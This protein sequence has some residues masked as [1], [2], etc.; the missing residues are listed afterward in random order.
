MPADDD[1]MAADGL[2]DELTSIVSAAAAAIIA[3]C[4]G[5]LDTRTKADLTPVTAA[6]HAAE[7]VIL[8]GLARLLPD[9]CVVSE[10]AVGRALPDRI[11]DRFVLVDPLDGT[12]ELV[13]G[14]DEFT[15]NLAIVDGG[16]PRLGIVAAPTQGLLWRG[17]E[18]S[19]AERLRLSPG[20]PANAAQGR[21]IIRTRP[22]PRA[23]LVAAVSRSHL[24]P[25]TEALLARLPIAARHAC[26]SALKFCQIAEGSADVYPRFSP[27][28]EWDVAAGHAVLA[29]AGGVV[30]T[31]EGAPLRYGRIAEN[32]RVPAF[33][34]WGDPEA[35]VRLGI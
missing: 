24:D 6:D 32:F 23:G 8:E 30:T 5:S 13:A 35:A 7:A 4:A 19:G 15:I 1:I 25:Q 34:A 21:S 31:P 10:E 16:R 9:T 27:T 11:P 14:R 20:A 2:L 22:A 12:R 29:A 3:A 26:G 33:V 17:I 18:G 28:C